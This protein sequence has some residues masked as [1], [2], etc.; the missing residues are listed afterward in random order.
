LFALEH[1][2]RS[3]RHPLYARPLVNRNPQQTNLDYAPGHDAAQ[4][5]QSHAEW[6]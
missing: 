2:V 4:V 5:A 6:T 3:M 1:E